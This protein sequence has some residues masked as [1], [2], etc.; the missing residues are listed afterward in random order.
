M[1]R[2]DILKMSLEKK[3]AAFDAA[4]QAHFD[5]VKSANGQ[6]L[7][8]KRNGY[9]TM[10]RWERQNEALKSRQE[11]IER[12]KMAI[13]RE[14]AAIRRVES[15]EFPAC[16]QKLIDE[17]TLAIWRKH[18]RFLFVEGVEKAR[19]VYDK[20]KN[21]IMARYHNRIKCREQF[22]KFK[23]IFNALVREFEAEKKSAETR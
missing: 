21:I 20:E 16:V 6:P 15:A 13:E 4:L 11:S 12:T 9:A 7:N 1:K 8:D 23:N 22:D 18:P 14:E 5:D 10:R 17:G 19:I 2:I 3:N